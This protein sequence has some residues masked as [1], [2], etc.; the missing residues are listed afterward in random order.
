ML[1]KVLKIIS[2]Q[3]SFEGMSGPVSFDNQGFRSVFTMEVFELTTSGT[4][5]AGTWDAENMFQNNRKPAILEADKR[6]LANQTL[7]V[8]TVLVSS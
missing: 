2:P 7:I 8:L 5:L 3:I 4:D 6:A 1:K